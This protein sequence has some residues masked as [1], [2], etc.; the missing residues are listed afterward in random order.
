MGT[1][2]LAISCLLTPLS[3]YLH[4]LPLYRLSHLLLLVVFLHHLR[5]ATR[6]GLWLAGLPP[7]PVAYWTYLALVVGLPIV[8]RIFLT[9]TE[10]Y[11]GTT[12]LQNSNTILHV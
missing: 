6:R 7:I 11:F 2:P 10:T 1:L 4:H 5:D 3:L 12:H 8:V 9:Q